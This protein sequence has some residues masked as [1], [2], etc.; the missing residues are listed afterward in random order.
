ME[1]LFGMRI[2]DGLGEQTGTLDRVLVDSRLRSATHV[3]VRS[4][5]VSED[6][7]I[8]LSLVQGAEGGVMRLRVSANELRQLPLYLEGRSGGPRAR[9]ET[10]LSGP[11]SSRHLLDES[12]GLDDSTVELGPDTEITSADGAKAKLA[13]I[14][15]DSGAPVI[16]V[17]Y[18]SGAGDR[19]RLPGAW[20]AE[21]SDQGITLTASRDD[22]TEAPPHSHTVPRE[23]PLEG[24][25]GMGGRDGET[26]EDKFGEDFTA[27]VRER[28]DVA[29][30]AP[31]TR[32]PGETGGRRADEIDA[33]E[34]YGR[35]PRR[36]G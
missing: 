6:V 26:R 2:E 32:R 1:L 25:S 8:P 28:E 18:A 19:E 35:P 12:L 22:V 20:I 17:V 14:G 31:P 5:A 13:G 24:L 11:A 10:A 7:L 9:T 30:H 21:L 15:I 3:V 33:G 34:A 29:T 4:P 36:T 16:D 27:E 23:R